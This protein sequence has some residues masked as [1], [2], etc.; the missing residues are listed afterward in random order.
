LYHYTAAG[1]LLYQRRFFGA[2]PYD[3]D[4]LNECETVIQVSVHREVVGSL[5]E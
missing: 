1:E 4:I 2:D 5:A 3:A